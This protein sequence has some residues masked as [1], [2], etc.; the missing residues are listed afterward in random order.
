MVR[1]V[2]TSLL[3]LV[4]AVS[5][6]LLIACANVANLLLVRAT[7][8]K[9]EIA[10]RAAI[11][12]ARGRIVRQLLTE[13]VL[14]SLAGGALG[15][16]SRHG[17]HSRAAGGE[18]RQHPAHR[19]RR[20]RRHRRLARRRVHARR[21]AGDRHPVRSD[22]RRCEASRADLNLTLKESGGRSGS[23]FRQNKARSILVVAEVALA[24]V[25]LIGASLLIRSFVALR[26]GESRVRRRTTS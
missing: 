15:P 26:A 20:L 22:S 17:R 8:R 6:V 24:L 13:S 12:A 3:V 21:L 2:R 1:N 5:F 10:I 9:R 11:G 16:R 14:L 25:L 19:R 23:G 4:G 7:G 18:P